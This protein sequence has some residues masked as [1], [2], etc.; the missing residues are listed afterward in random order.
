MRARTLLV[1][2]AML[3]LPGL[4][5]ALEK[6]PARFRDDPER[7][8]WRGW[9]TVSL[10]YYN[11]CTGWTWVWSGWSPSDRLGVI[12]DNPCSG[13]PE[14]LQGG[15]VFVATGAPG[16]YGYTGTVEVS[17]VTPEGCPGELLEQQPFLPTSGWQEFTWTARLRD[18]LGF[19]Q[20][21][22][23][24]PAPGNPVAL[25][26]DHPAAAPGSPPA[27]GTC[28]PTTR[29]GRSFVWA[30]AEPCPGVPFQ[31]GTCVAELL[32][33]AVVF[34][35]DWHSDVAPSSWGSIKGLY[36]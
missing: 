4:S 17:V 13:E 31:D 26:T 14:Y 24:G 23:L 16:G 32:F 30:G 2:A 19:T 12:Y 34:C 15:R 25:L 7:A 11:L 35:H 28:W 5:P 6:I 18:D 10:A 33:G 29:E 27:C 21:V 36:R 9:G 8:G 1:A 3:L 22:T 20:T